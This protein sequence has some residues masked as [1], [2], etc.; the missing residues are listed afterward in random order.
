[1]SDP[2]ALVPVPYYTPERIRTSNAETIF[3][4]RQRARPTT[5]AV[6]AQRPAAPEADAGLVYDK[7]GIFVGDPSLGWI[8][9]IWV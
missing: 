4:H 2:A 8:V 3:S 1:M 6:Y 7:S 9:N 5:H